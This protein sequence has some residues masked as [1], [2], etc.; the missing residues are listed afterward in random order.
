[1]DRHDGL[2]SPGHGSRDLA[3]V[4]QQVIRIDVDQNR[5]RTDPGRCLSR[6]DE[7]VRRHDHLIAPL[8]TNRAQRQLEAIRAVGNSHTVGDTMEF[9]VR[10]LELVHRLAADERR[11][12]E[13]VGQTGRDLVGDLGLLSG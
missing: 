12:C 10:T 8:Y 2:R 4:D 5:D 11:S 13:D 6:G 1:M 7:R 9:S 3:R